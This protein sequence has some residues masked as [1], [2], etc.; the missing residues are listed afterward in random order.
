[1]H[2]FFEIQ[3]HRFSPSLTRIT[4]SVH[5]TFLYIGVISSNEM[6]LF[7]ELKKEGRKEGRKKGRK[8]GRKEGR[9]ELMNE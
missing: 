5:E 6:T 1:M 4:R 3:T 2:A 9:R 8:E 7:L